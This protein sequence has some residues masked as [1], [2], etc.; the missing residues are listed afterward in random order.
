MRFLIVLFL[1]YITMAACTSPD[2]GMTAIDNAEAAIKAA[3]TR[4][5]QK[6]ADSFTADTANIK[7]STATGLCRLAVIYKKLADNGDKSLEDYNNDRALTY[8]AAACTLDADSV[9]AFRLRVPLEDAAAFDVVSK[10]HAMEHT[11]IDLGEH[12]PQDSSI[13]SMTATDSLTITD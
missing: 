11:A 5:A 12:A 10:L 2:G 4:R 9:E 6:E 1:S 7:A 13:I 8:Y 3:D